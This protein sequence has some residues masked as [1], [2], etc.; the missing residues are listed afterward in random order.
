MI[1]AGML[2][3]RQMMALEYQ[4]NGEACYAQETPINKDATTLNQ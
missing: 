1:K 3:F 2:F 4:K